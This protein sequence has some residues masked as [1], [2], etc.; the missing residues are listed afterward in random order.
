MLAAPRELPY[1]AFE[2]LRKW[3]HDSLRDQHECIYDALSGKPL[4]ALQQCVAIDVQQKAGIAA[5]NFARKQRGGKSGGLPD[6]GL[7]DV[8]DVHG[9]SDWLHGLHRKRLTGE[10]QEYSSAALITAGPAAGKTT[11]ISQVILLTLEKTD[12][13]PIIIKVCCACALA[14]R[15]L[16]QPCP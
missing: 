10:P 11:V 8:R 16:W 7:Q 3:W 9:L 2:E 13:I 12:L 6:D 5:I 4:K 14:T 15:P 1:A